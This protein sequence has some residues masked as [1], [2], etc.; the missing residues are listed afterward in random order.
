MRRAVLWLVVLSGCATPGLRAQFVA[1]E[2]LTWDRAKYADDEAVVLYRADTTEL[3]NDGSNTYTHARRHEVVAVQSEGGFDLAEI[4]VPFQ[5]NWKL[6]DFKARVVQPDGTR[7]EFDDRELLTDRG[8]KGDTDVNA[9]FF[10]FPDVRL[11]SVL[12]YAWVIET[13]YLWNADEQ[14]T[15][16]HHPVREYHF[17]LTALKELVFETIEFSGRS[18]I[19]VR[20]LADGRH[21]LLFDLKDLPRRERA[22]YAPHFSFTEPRWAWRVLAYHTRAVTYDWLRTWDDVL[23]QRADAFFVAH[24]LD[25]GLDFTV[26]LAGCQDL[27]CKLEKTLAQLRQRT[28]TRGVQWNRDAKLKAALASGK[29]SVVERALLMKHVLE[30]QGLD[31]WLAYGTARLGQAAST[32]FPRLSQFDRLFVH[33][34]VQ[35]GVAQALTI[36][37]GCDSCAAGQIPAEYQGTPIYVFKGK[38]VYGKAKAEGRWVNLFQDDA[39]ADTMVVTHQAVVEGN[40]TVRDT[41]VVKALG[42]AAEELH[43]AQRTEKTPLTQ[44]EQNVVAHFTPLASVRKAEW[45]DCTLAHCEY[46]TTVEFPA[47]A[48][49]VDGR[50]L[51]PTTF[52]RPAWENL[53]EAPARGIP[54]HFTEASAYDEVVELAAPEGFE[55][56]DAPR[57]LEVKLDELSV[58]VTVE[59]TPKGARLRRTLQHGVGIV[60]KAGYPA[61][62]EAIETFRRG[63]RQVLVFAPKRVAAA[64]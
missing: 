43:E 28:S 36:D 53:F 5:K 49:R 22:D 9:K 51:V 13:P 29:A 60:E 14:E 18:P 44:R 58:L 6:V 50:V 10:R 61:M 37:V 23:E 8:G 2:K 47:E 27:G 4:R 45:K 17:E 26:D 20:S 41:C 12:E 59:K 39:P 11:G 34:P 54:V 55:L 62:R 56:V 38:S 42:E 31:V 33:L 3:V 7:R 15:L 63:R 64:Q 52:L 40:G 21:Q 16:G 35:P 24:E 46:Q 19:D 1:D 48:S 32:N 30:A 25:E 57:P